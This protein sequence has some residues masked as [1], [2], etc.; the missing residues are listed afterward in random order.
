[1]SNITYHHDDLDFISVDA[2]N[3]RLVQDIL[4]HNAYYHTSIVF[5]QPTGLAERCLNAEPPKVEGSRVFK[6]YMLVL[7]NGSPVAAFDLF[8]G[9][10]NYKTASI[11]MFLVHESM[12]RKGIATHVLARA[13]PAF[14]R[15]LHPAVET[16]SVSLTDNNVP[17]LRCLV[18][19]EYERTN[20]WSKLDANGRPITAVTFKRKINDALKA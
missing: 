13:M 12:H 4:N 9:F 1:M 18:K 15:E 19:C 6:K 20:T 17:A 10:P 16:I 3:V 5:T 2:E 8:V 7:Q 14:L 11:A